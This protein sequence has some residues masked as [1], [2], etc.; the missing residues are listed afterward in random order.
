[1]QDDE[2]PWT[3][4]HT[5]RGRKLLG[6]VIASPHSDQKWDRLNHDLAFLAE[7]A[8]SVEEIRVCFWFL[9]LYYFN[10]HHEP[11]S[12]LWQIS[13]NPELRKRLSFFDDMDAV[14]YPHI[15]ESRAYAE[16]VNGNEVAA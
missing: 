13:I 14:E 9:I 8:E 4:T 6:P 10:T 11:D 2:E 7:A 3:A 12:S 15:P 1:M 16:A 5:A